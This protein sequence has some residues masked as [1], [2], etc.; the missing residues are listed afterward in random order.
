MAVKVDRTIQNAKVALE[1]ELSDVI[2]RSVSAFH[3]RQPEWMVTDADLG[4]ID[5]SQFDNPQRMT[6]ATR[7]EITK[8]DMTL[9]ISKDGKARSVK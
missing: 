2:H 9:V 5:I 8:K 7:V 3:A 4:I 6:A 1:Q